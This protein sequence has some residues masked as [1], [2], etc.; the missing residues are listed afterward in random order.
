ML[1]TVL[2]LGFLLLGVVQGLTNP[3]QV[4]KRLAEHYVVTEVNALP[5]ILGEQRSQGAVG[6]FRAIGRR[7]GV[8]FHVV[9]ELPL[10]GNQLRDHRLVAFDAVDL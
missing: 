7:C 9:P 6:G 5:V 1:Q 3:L 10:Q 2:E 8:V 4:D